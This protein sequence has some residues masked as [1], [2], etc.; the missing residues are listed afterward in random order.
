MTPTGI[1]D[2]LISGTSTTVQLVSWQKKDFTS[3]TTGLMTGLGI[4][5]VELLVAPFTQVGTRNKSYFNFMCHLNGSE[6]RDHVLQCFRI[7]FCPQD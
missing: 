5:W 4:L 6:G 3:F 1:L 2:R 7:L